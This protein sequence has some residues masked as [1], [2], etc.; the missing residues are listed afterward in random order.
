V[1]AAEVG[2]ALVGLLPWFGAM[3]VLLV[4]SAFFSGS[5]SA[6]FSLGHAE[7][8]QLADGG[9]KGRAV[10]RLLDQP[11]RLLA[12]LLLG[13]EIVNISLSAVGVRMVF[14]LDQQGAPV[15]P[16]LNILFVTP[17]LLLFG[18]IAP[19]AVAVRLGVVWARA[20]ALPLTAFGFVVSPVRALL[21]GLAE[22]A[23]FWM[24]KNLADP[25]PD[26]L[27]EAQFKALVEL[28]E[29]QGVLDADEAELIN[30]V[31]DLGDTP[32]SRLMTS[33]PD[34]V[35]LPLT[36]DLEEILGTVRR[37]R[38]SRIPIYA[39]EVD[40]IRGI[41]LAKDLL[42]FRWSDQELTPRELEDRLQ[43]AYIVPA[44]KPADELL[45]EF[46]SKRLHMAVVFDEYGAMLGVITLQDVLGALFR[47]LTEERGNSPA[48]GIETIAEGV[49]R[50][51]AKLPV[52]QWNRAMDPPLPES[53][54]YTT[55][56]GY[57]FHLFGRLPTKG[58]QI[59]DT[60]WNFQVTGVEGS[61]LTW[62]TATRAG[63][64]GQFQRLGGGKDAR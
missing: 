11:R 13:N 17:L 42:P 57:V 25:L 44:S 22:A 12:T 40:Q 62:I 30:R 43:P 8:E 35:A 16:W 27:A 6:L 61:R 7:V 14:Q 50:L 34:V 38:Y 58:E 36:A 2:A 55:V 4:F 53:D 49:F 15:P 37:V 39:G 32:V 54:A 9:R 31:F 52:E 20:V 45:R 51:P 56:A 10:R 26:A 64:T 63:Q 5:E 3:A 1:T 47:G 18:E 33:R 23:L 59:G 41:L 48:P 21:H 60:A 46:Q 24:P 29:S 28:G 19:K